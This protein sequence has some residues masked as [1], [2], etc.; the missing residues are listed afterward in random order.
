MLLPYF[1][2]DLIMWI[3]F[4]NK[5]I[6]GHKFFSFEIMALKFAR[7]FEGEKDRKIKI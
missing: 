5:W 6:L 3:K 4:K 7:Y 1:L 2:H